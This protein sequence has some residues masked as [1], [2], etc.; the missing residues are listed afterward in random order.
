[1]HFT[2]RSKQVHERRVEPCKRAWRV[3]GVF[4]THHSVFP[5][6]SVFISIWWNGGPGQYINYD[7]YFNQSKAWWI[8]VEG[9]RDIWVPTGRRPCLW[10]YIPGRKVKTA[11]FLLCCASVQQV[12]DVFAFT[13]TICWSCGMQGLKQQF[14][15]DTRAKEYRC[16]T[17]FLYIYKIIYNS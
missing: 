6:L 17:T 16:W 1:M 4:F 14:C 15:K 2:L 3:S 10:S 5:L 7:L 8:Y 12:M 11:A 9:V 13:L